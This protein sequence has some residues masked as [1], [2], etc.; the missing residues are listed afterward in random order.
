MNEPLETVTPEKL[1][2][3][4]REDAKPATAFLY[5]DRGVYHLGV[6]KEVRYERSHLIAWVYYVAK[7]TGRKMGA[8]QSEHAELPKY[9]VHRCKRCFGQE[10][11]YK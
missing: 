10:G 5:S 4:A 3:H 7:C 11:G 8:Y 1:A 2:K 6:R 9:R